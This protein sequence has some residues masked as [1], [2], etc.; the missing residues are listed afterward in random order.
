[1][2]SD[3]KPISCSFYD[4]LEEAATLNREIDL[5]Y[6]GPNQLERV[7]SRIE[8]LKI[9]DKVEYMVLADGTEIRLDSIYSVDGILL[10]NY[11]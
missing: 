11:C 3:Y 5:V 7:R 1:M 2:A 4:R 9:M 6:Q 8:T 10:N